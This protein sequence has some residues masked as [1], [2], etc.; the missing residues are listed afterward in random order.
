MDLV[1]ELI[2]KGAP[3]PIIKRC[4]EEEHLRCQTSLLSKL[5]IKATWCYVVFAMLV[6]WIPWEIVR[7]EH[8]AILLTVGGC[9]LGMGLF[10]ISYWLHSATKPFTLARLILEELQELGLRPSTIAAWDKSLSLWYLSSYLAVSILSISI[11]ATSIFLAGGIK[12]EALSAGILFSLATTII[13]YAT[14]KMSK[15]ANIIR[16]NP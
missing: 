6:M 7:R 11:A 15:V 13:L 10:F 16:K 9:S 1:D 12:V 5:L 14:R 4:A 2:I 3:L 8:I